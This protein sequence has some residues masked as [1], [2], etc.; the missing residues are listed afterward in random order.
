MIDWKSNLLEDYH[1]KTLE[2]EVM[3]HYMLQLQI[4]TV[5]TSYWFKLDSKEK[6]ENRF[7]GVL[8]IFLR[9]MLLRE[10]V[11]FFRPSWKDLLDYERTLSLEKY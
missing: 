1:F 11:F 7:G 8:Y 2:N 3:K 6:F 10:G 5:A 4:Y 9:G